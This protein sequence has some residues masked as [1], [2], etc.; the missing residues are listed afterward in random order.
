MR[1]RRIGGLLLG[2]CLALG[3]CGTDEVRDAADSVAEKAVAARAV[4]RWTCETDQVANQ[5]EEHLTTEIAIAEDGRFSY[6]VVD[7]GGPGPLAGTWRIDDLQ[8]SLSIPWQDEGRNGF[9][10]WQHLL[11]ADPPTHAD[12][13]ASSGAVQDLDISIDGPDVVRLHQ[14][15]DG[16]A[17]GGVGYAWDVTCERT[18]RVPGT[19]PPTIPSTAAGD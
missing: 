16:G 10:N 4:G 8:L 5:Y 14:D 2:A 17:I 12:G 3:A 13:R 18:S 6:E 15:D 9:I 11:D 19:I 7:G 1:S